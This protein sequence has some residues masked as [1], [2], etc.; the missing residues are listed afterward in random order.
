MLSH[1]HTGDMDKDVLYSTFYN[2]KP[3][4]IDC[5]KQGNDIETKVYS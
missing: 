2:R 1:I 3:V 4:E 5:P